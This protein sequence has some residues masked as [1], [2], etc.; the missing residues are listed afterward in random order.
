MNFPAWLS[1]SPASSAPA[2]A[3]LGLRRSWFS[4]KMWFVDLLVAGGVFL[5]NLPIIPAYVREP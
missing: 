4:G 5:Y 2:A 3:G 1:P